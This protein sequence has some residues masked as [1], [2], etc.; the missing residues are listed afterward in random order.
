MQFQDMQLKFKNPAK[1]KT[2]PPAVETTSF[3]TEEDIDS[4]SQAPSHHVQV[5]KKKTFARR[6]T[7]FVRRKTFNFGFSS[8][9]DREQSIPP[10][11]VEAHSQPKLQSAARKKPGPAAM[12]MLKAVKKELG[13]RVGLQ[14]ALEESFM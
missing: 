6:R 14:M 4:L 8:A 1:P 5:Q 2:P 9:K 11:S 7:E 10:R 12:E 3:T 13:S